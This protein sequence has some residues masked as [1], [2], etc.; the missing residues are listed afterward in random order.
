[1]NEAKVDISHGIDHIKAVTKHCKY[2]LTFCKNLSEINKR[3]VM[4]AC[5]LHDIDDRKY[6]PNNNNYDNAKVILE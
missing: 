6:F 5:I 3:N 1:M 4:L 2:A